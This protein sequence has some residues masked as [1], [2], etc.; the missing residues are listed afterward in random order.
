MDA[1]AVYLIIFGMLVAA[2]FSGVLSLLNRI[3]KLIESLQKDL[4]P[5]AEQARKRETRARDAQIEDFLAH[6][7]ANEAGRRDM[8]MDEYRKLQ[9]KAEVAGLTIEEYEA[10]E[11]KRTENSPHT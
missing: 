6:R 11:A 1:I 9:A 5:L 8:T 3:A 7:D 10:R 2:G 4:G